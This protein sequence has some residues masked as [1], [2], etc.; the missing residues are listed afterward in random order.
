M[1]WAK[2]CC[3]QGRTLGLLKHTSL[4]EFV[5]CIGIHMVRVGG[6]STVRPIE[7]RIEASL[8]HVSK[9]GAHPT[10]TNVSYI[11]FVHFN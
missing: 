7:I 2:D 3:S 1:V 10:N 8:M 6:L 9:F 11:V 5:E 4:S